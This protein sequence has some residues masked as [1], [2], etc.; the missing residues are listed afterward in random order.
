MFS[1]LPTIH[2]HFLTRYN[3]FFDLPERA[4]Q[5]RTPSSESMLQALDIL[6][7][8]RYNVCLSLDLRNYLQTYDIEDLLHFWTWFED[9][10][11][12][13]GNAVNHDENMVP[14]MSH[15]PNDMPENMDELWLKR[16]LTLFQFKNEKCLICNKEH[17]IVELEPC[18]HCVCT[19]C[20]D[21]YT[22]CPVCGRP[23]DNHATFLKHQAIIYKADRSAWKTMTCLDLGKDIKAF[24]KNKLRSICQIAQ[25][26]SVH[27]KKTLSYIMDA[28]IQ[29]LPDWLPEQ[30]NSKQMQAI[31]LALFIQKNISQSNEILRRYLKNATDVLRLLAV[32]SGEDGTLMP[33]TV[34]RSIDAKR[35]DVIQ[36]YLTRLPKSQCQH[37]DQQYAILRTQHHDTMIDFVEQTYHFNVVKLTRHQR[38]L[39]LSI[40]DAFDEDSLIEDL[41][42]HRALWIRLGEFLHPGDYEKRFP[43]ICRAFSVIR[44]KLW[45]DRKCKAPA[46]RTWR[47]QLEEAIQ[48]RDKGSL[49]TLMSARPGEFAR[50]LDRILRGF[51][52]KATLTDY[53]ADHLIQTG[54]RFYLDLIYKK[55]IFKSLKSLK[56]KINFFVSDAKQDIQCKIRYIKCLKSFLQH[57][58]TPL[59][60]QLWGHF[61]TRKNKLPKRVFYPAGSIRKIYWT[62]DNRPTIPHF[63]TDSIRDGIVKELLH[64]FEQKPH[65]AQSIIDKT[66]D[67]VTFPFNERNN[68]TQGIHLS[69]GSSLSLPQE[70]NNDKMRLFLHWCQKDGEEDVDLDL[71]VAFFNKN[72]KMVNGC[73]YYQL[74]CSSHHSAMYYARHSGDFRAAPYPRGATEYVDI[75]RDRAIKAGIRYAV[76]LVQVYA[77]VDFDNF[78]R[79]YTGIMYRNETHQ[80][81]YFDPQTV[82][83]KYALEGSARAYIPI[84]FDLIENTTLEVQ[85]YLP[86]KN[87][88]I[89][90]LNSN[91]KCIKDMVSA[92]TSFYRS[93]PRAMRYDIAL[94]QAAARTTQVWV[95]FENGSVM[96]F[97]R[98]YDEDT[99]TFYNKLLRGIAQI[100]KLN[101]TTA[102]PAVPEFT[103]P[104]LAFL[105]N[106]D[107]PMN[108]ESEYYI[109]INDHLNE[110]YSW[111]ELL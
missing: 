58:S 95:R 21:G 78:E 75:D 101:A 9:V 67:T 93:R 13:A 3:L 104:S 46:F 12:S 20:F 45:Y 25:A 50:H 17:T 91:E 69:P 70:N 29:D 8:E 80:T 43:K 10:W 88:T 65:F 98:G 111:L 33:H 77:G 24:A 89:N 82:R 22:G 87:A 7:A 79:A 64:R 42:R 60:I 59:L 99:W 109:I 53:A 28:F 26:L 105:M 18:H 41:L 23:I 74:Q 107:V 36:K 30:F 81:A 55:G 48:K 106:G 37:I 94:M 83:F 4:Q 84:L 76:M 96:P 38:R 68:H 1:F 2:G 56:Q 57:L 61:G 73:T 92:L 32:L 71:S 66:L 108:N 34:T 39:F 15:F 100:T 97:N 49:E 16:F 110:R 5:N 40:L 62:D 14:L 35:Q 52:S 31:V 19:H 90:N 44:K 102:W 72:W 103:A 54:A 6:L 86:S 47:S 27:D 51:S 63:Y 85:C 11:K